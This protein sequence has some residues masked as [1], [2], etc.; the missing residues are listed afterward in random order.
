M[1]CSHFGL[2]R[3][4]FNNTP[5]PSF[6]YST[7]DH[8][9]A[10]ATLQYATLHRKGFVLVTGEVG[11][12]KTLI[13]RMFVR[14]MDHQA[15]T[16]VIT[17][18]HLNARQLL[19]AI[20]N[21]FELEVPPDATNLQL[22]DIL[23]EYL[24]DQFAR[25][26]FVVVLLDEGQNLPDESF[27][28]LRMLG[29]LE[30]DDAKLLQVCIL[31]QPELRDRFRQE[32]MRQLDQ[33]LF[34]RFHL[35][36]L[37]H[38]QTN[39]YVVRR[40]H[41]AGCARCDLFTPGAIERVYQGSLG[42]PR[43]I[44]QICDNALLAAYAKG[45]ESVTPDIVDQVLEQEGL[46]K[47]TTA[48][49]PA[50]S[51]AAG[52]DE[53]TEERIE[54]IYGARPELIQVAGAEPVGREGHDVAVV[55]HS[56]TMVASAEM[57][58]GADRQSMV[59]QYA[60]R[61][62]MSGTA[63]QWPA[64]KATIEHHRN[65]I[66]NEIDQV[67]LRCQVAEEQ[68]N[69]LTQTSAP[70]QELEE[71]QEL[72]QV[73]SRLI[74]SEISATRDGIREL[75][76]QTDAQLAETQGQLQALKTQTVTRDA[77]EALE[78]QQAERISETLG[79]LD[80]YRRH[81]DELVELLKHQCDQ[82]QNSVTGLADSCA[83][84]RTELTDHVDGR[85]NALQEELEESRR[86][87]A[88]ADELT[89]L[90]ES[91]ARTRLELAS[92]F[93]ARL[94]E[95]RERIHQHAAATA[96][97]SKK[98]REEVEEIRG[99]QSRAQEELAAELES[100]L[101]ALQD[102]VQGQ[103]ASIPSAG[104]LEVLR[105]TAAMASDVEALRQ[106]AVKKDELEALRQ[107]TAQSAEV[108]RERLR[109]A[110]HGFH[111]LRDSQNQLSASL[112]AELQGSL[113]RTREEVD[114]NVTQ[115]CSQ[116][117][118][119]LSETDVRQQGE[120][121]QNRADID[122]H[123][124]RLAVH[125]GLLKTHETAIEQHGAALA[126]QSARLDDQRTTVE[127]HETR[128]AGHHEFLESHQAAIEAQGTTL[129]NQ[130]ARLD[131]QRTTVEQHETRLAGHHESLK[132]H[133]ATIETHGTALVNQAARLDEQQTMIGQHDVMFAEQGG[134]IQNLLEDMTRQ[135]QEIGSLAQ[136]AGER[137]DAV[138]GAMD[139]LKQTKVDVADFERL[140]D[141]HQSA[142][143]E[144]LAGL[145]K[146]AQDLLG[147]KEVLAARLDQLSTEQQGANE[148]LASRISDQEQ[149]VLQ[150][151]RRLIEHRAVVHQQFAEMEMQF[152]CRADLEQLRQD[153]TAQAA[154]LSQQIQANR[155]AVADLMQGITERF[156]LTHERLEGLGQAAD[157]SSQELNELRRVQA[158]D[159]ASLLQQLE[160]QRQATKEQFEAALANWTRNQ[161]DIEQ[162]RMTAASADALEE[163]RQLQE[164]QSQEVL[165]LL[166]EHRRNLETLVSTVARRCDEMLVRIDALPANI[167][168]TDDLDALDEKA[169]DQKASIEAAIRSVADQCEQTANSLH[170][171]E[172]R[173]ASVEDLRQMRE[174]QAADLD[175]LAQRLDGQSSECQQ[176]F[177]AINSRWENLREELRTL[178]K[179][180]TSVEKFENT[181]RLLTQDLTT[182]K[183]RVNDV[184][185]RRQKDVR[186][187]VD[188]VQ[189][190]TGRVKTLEAME[191][192]EPVRI[193]LRPRAAEELAEL[194]ASAEG[195]ASDLRGL[196][197]SA[198][199]IGTQL[200]DSSAQIEQVMRD[201]LGS[202]EQITEQSEQLKVSAAAS[203]NILQALR[204][205]NEAID[206]KLKS[207]AWHGQLRRAEE[208]AARLEQ[209]LPQYLHVEETIQSWERQ[210]ADAEQFV[211]RLE[212]LLG[213]AAR[214]TA[215]L[216]QV[217]AM[218][219]GVAGKASDLAATVESARAIDEQ[220][221]P[222][223]SR[224]GHK[225]GRNVQDVNWPQYR[226]H[227]TTAAG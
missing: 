116:L 95:I 27:E 151:R 91:H 92:Q 105:N 159:V 25:D 45:R 227:A 153:H 109:R 112:Q 107:E 110:V 49:A 20:C 154:E 124:S 81:I 178:A 51:V 184:S 72:H 201:W 193:E 2:H 190:L 215:G 101:A 152:A 15:S 80:Q 58:A 34:R 37:T 114:A 99:N 200:R 8:E 203:G 177:D 54:H 82:A 186:V 23:Q 102:S 189:K 84:M 126:Q 220:R 59:G 47:T 145:D 197:D 9:E 14:Q 171:L 136:V 41:V 87:A 16:A 182:L 6:Y 29:N 120:I 38:Q 28:A 174:L 132:S 166:A 4:P 194:N 160:D 31:G 46:L 144:L 93:E 40:L 141:E 103:L 78:R 62:V 11:A 70:V 196:L 158:E 67:T 21:E 128:L 137:M 222:T 127:Q 55:A 162:L 60:L 115:A 42:I 225:N 188:A 65:E 73:Q 155:Q 133:Q 104:D 71:L 117:R 113:A 53:R 221:R 226:T 187:L 1:Y 119:D 63:G 83:R 94:T 12:G 207:P 3:P 39:E 48:S 223:K 148:G 213:E 26:R 79:R 183:Q 206:S 125:K 10:L 123:E 17:H 57:P 167:A 74:L 216:S 50:S 90:R 157:E 214:V 224:N 147:L 33:R 36:G 199:V 156:R 146:R 170:E 24:L 134:V 52:N 86:Q 131:E 121:D 66:Q 149:Q 61:D 85:I 13:G 176:E 219:A 195:R 69:A 108:V 19:A 202:A 191:R 192:P 168:T 139:A 169:R 75:A 122:R 172:N 130:S 211:N 205:C 218:M 77:V 212:R 165:Q 111:T 163:L 32:S 180:S 181:E 88:R 150:L 173:A 204:K 161:Q 64:V 22:A 43:V 143:D 175:Q 140:R 35:S 100:K 209:A 96:E 138:S 5:D 179:S 68:L 135:S 97:H 217:G 56:A 89:D 98:L 30:A 198:G 142:M 164:T 210:R 18:T 106:T 129:V 118:G 185:Q 7:P 44:N 208:I 76:E